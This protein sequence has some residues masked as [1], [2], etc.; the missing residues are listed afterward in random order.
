MA[1]MK[2]TRAIPRC[3][4][5]LLQNAVT[6]VSGEIKSGRSRRGQKLVCAGR[7]LASIFHRVGPLGP[8]P[9]DD[10]SRF[11]GYQRAIENW[12]LTRSKVS[13]EIASERVGTHVCIAGY[14]FRP[15]MARI[16]DD[17]AEHGKH[18]RGMAFFAREN[19]SRWAAV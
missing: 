5:T 11:R 14:L 15:V 16:A 12:T 6:Y 1:V 19:M 3:P 17:G 8:S 13:G 10:R 2:W 18:A 4:R 9:L 7:M